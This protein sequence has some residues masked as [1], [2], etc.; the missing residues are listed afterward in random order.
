M[1]QASQ[2]RRSEK[3]CRLEIARERALREKGRRGALE[4]ADEHDVN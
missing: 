4:G 2:I 3:L 1:D